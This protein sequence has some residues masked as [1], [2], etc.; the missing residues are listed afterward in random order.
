MERFFIAF[1]ITVIIYGT[2]YLLRCDIAYKN[3]RKI[4]NAIN[5]YWHDSYNCEECIR[6]LDNMESFESTIFR[7]WDFGCKNIL[8]KEDYEIIKSYIK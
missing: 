4:I 6:L 3:Q 8:P 1:S 5:G 7:V 2:F